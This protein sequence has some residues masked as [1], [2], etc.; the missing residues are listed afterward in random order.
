MPQRRK[1]RTNKNK[2][3]GP[4]DLSTR[5]LPGGTEMEAL[6]TGIALERE[7][8][9]SYQAGYG[10]AATLANRSTL[11]DANKQQ[12]WFIADASTGLLR[13]LNTPQLFT[14]FT[15][16]I[17]EIF[18][19]KAAGKNITLTEFSKGDAWKRVTGMTK[20]TPLTG[21]F[22]PLE[23]RYVKLKDGVFMHH[24]MTAYPMPPP[25]I[26]PQHRIAY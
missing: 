25:K 8:G 19:D 13:S 23:N 3:V 2:P 15:D 7:R 16:E 10:Y 5:K 6:A 22:E 14:E 17:E 12:P 4:F 11:K 20:N 24:R 21:P 9:L 1:A 18:T 26:P